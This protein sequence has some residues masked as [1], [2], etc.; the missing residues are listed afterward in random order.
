MGLPE[1][2]AALNREMKQANINQSEL[3]RRIGSAPSMIN[4]W[5]KGNTAQPDLSKVRDIE[6][7]LELPP[8]HLTRHFG[9]VP[10]EEDA[11]TDV[12]AAVE[13]A[14]ITDG[15]RDALLLLYNLFR[16]QAELA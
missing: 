12:V 4:A 16:R 2:T 5:L 1:F 6:R 10:Y 8:G 15:Q 7:A 13:H 11:T 3:G 14:P 9:W